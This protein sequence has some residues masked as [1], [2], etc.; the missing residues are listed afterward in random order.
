[1]HAAG[2]EGAADEGPVGFDKAEDAVDW[3]F[4]GDVGTD[5]GELVED[6]VDESGAV[7]GSDE[8]SFDSWS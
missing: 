2:S 5:H 1:M 3:D 8:E 4:V 7:P 6:A